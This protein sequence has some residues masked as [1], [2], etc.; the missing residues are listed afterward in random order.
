MVQLHGIPT[1]I[2][3]DQD[4]VFLSSFWQTLFQ[5]QGT[6]LQMSSIYHPQI[7]GQTEVIN[8]ILEQY[9]RC[10]A[11]DQPQNWVDWLPWAEFSYNTSIQESMGITPFEVVYGMALPTVLS[12]VPGTSQLEAVDSYLQNW[13]VLL[14]D[15]GSNLVKNFMDRH[16]RD[17][18]FVIGD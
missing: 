9:L 6:S 15:L 7:D 11:G 16:R 13:D 10:F 2:I 17:V 12:Y 5:L 8:R 3:S 4:K 18:S 1:S 14:R